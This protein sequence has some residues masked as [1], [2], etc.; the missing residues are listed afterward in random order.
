MRKQKKGKNLDSFIAAHNRAYNESRGMIKRNSTE[1]KEL[2]IGKEFV[3][4]I[5]AVGSK[6]DGIGKHNNRTVI[7]SDAKIG[8]KVK[9][10]IT[11]ITKTVVFAELTNK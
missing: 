1:E 3:V 7:V 11:N 8:D 2:F 5:I 6:G 10:K 9:V 4:T